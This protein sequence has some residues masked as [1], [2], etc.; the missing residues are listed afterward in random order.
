M[1]TLD[2]AIWFLFISHS[3]EGLVSS[4]SKALDA[5]LIFHIGKLE[6]IIEG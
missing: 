5:A 1:L 3:R 2:W 6:Q 4:S